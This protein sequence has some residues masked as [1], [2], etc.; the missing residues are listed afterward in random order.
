MPARLEHANLTV[1]DLDGVVRFIVTALPEFRLR[2]DGP[3]AD[4]TRWVH[5]G[6]DETYLALNAAAAGSS[7]P[8]PPYQGSPGLNHLAYE[9]EDVEA[10]RTRLRAAGFRESGAAEAHPHRRRVYFYDPDGN[11]WEFVQYLIDDPRA[12]HDYALPDVFVPTGR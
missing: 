5:V 10:V 8:A 9:V 12:R 6:T 1:Q 2:Y 4:G 11:D 7:P 3:G